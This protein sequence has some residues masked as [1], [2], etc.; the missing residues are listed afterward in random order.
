MRTFRAGDIAVSSVVIVEV[1]PSDKPI[2]LND[3][4]TQ[5]TDPNVPVP[6]VVNYPVNVR[7]LRRARPMRAPDTGQHTEEVLAELRYDR[8]DIERFR[9]ESAVE[10]N[11]SLPIQTWLLADPRAPRSVAANAKLKGVL[12]LG[13]HP[14]VLDLFSDLYPSPRRTGASMRTAPR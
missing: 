14:A 7:G 3:I 12:P 4:F 11:R 8:A 5:P 9:N 2:T 10:V 13:Q 1:L 6:L